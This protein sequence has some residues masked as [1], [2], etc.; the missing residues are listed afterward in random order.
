MMRRARP[1]LGTLVEIGVTMTEAGDPHRAEAA[2]RAAFEAVAALESCLS[3]FL[4]DSDLGRFHRLKAGEATPVHAHTVQVL[5]AARELA[6]ASDGLFDI[7]L[8]SGPQGWRLL[9]PTPEQ[10]ATWQLQRLTPHTRLDLGG[11]AK[12][13]AVD[14]AIQALQQGGSS[15]GWVN[16]GGDLRCFGDLDLPLQLRDEHSGGTRSF[17]VLRDGAFATSHYGPHSRSALHG[18]NR[19]DAVHVSVAA[20]ECLWADALTKIVA[21]TGRPDHPLLARHGAQAWWHTRPGAG[22]CGLL[23]A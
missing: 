17:G 5:L 2:I 6:E 12:G 16:A 11:I 9:P 4:P 18:P 23:H 22:E 3:R 1:A 8:G 20:P 10:P 7:S 15:A 13:Y 14:L 21:L 19:P